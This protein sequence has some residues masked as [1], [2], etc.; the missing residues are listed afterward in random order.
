TLAACGTREEH[1]PP[2]NPYGIRHVVLVSIDTLRADRL[3]CYGYSVLGRSPS[4][5]ID[6]LA[7]RGVLFERHLS[8][9]TTTLASHTSL[10]TGT[11]P[12]THGVPR[13]GFEVADENVM[14]AE[15]LAEAGFYTA[16][17]IGAAPLM[18]AVRFD[19][20][21]R[22]YDFRYSRAA[23][24]SPSGHQRRADEVTDA[25]LDWLDGTFD[26]DVDRPLFLFV[27]YFDVHAPYEAP[28]PFRGSFAPEGL[29]V[30][31]QSDA[32]AP[33]AWLR[34]RAALRLEGMDG[35]GADARLDPG[36]LAAAE[37]EL[38]E[39]VAFARALDG[40]YTAELAFVDHELGRLFEGL[41]ARGVLDGALVVVTSDHGETFAEHTQCF[42]HG[43]SV[44]DSEAH[45][46]LIVAFPR[47]ELAGTRVARPVSAVDVLPGVLE[48]LEL[49]APAGVEGRSLLDTLH[50]D[51]P[52][53]VVFSE[54][55][56]P[57]GV[58][59]YESLPPWIN[60][61]KFQAAYDGHHKLV[62]RAADGLRFL[63]T[64]AD[65][66]LEQRNL[67][68]AGD[69]HMDLAAEALQRAMDA[70]LDAAQPL[71]TRPVTQRDQLEA[72]RALGYVDGAQGGEQED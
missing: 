26:G 35:S 18:S 16:G 49:R 39:A 68:L 20:G 46:P 27:H 17:F 33:D 36:F 43:E 28:E 44:Y 10:M 14:L 23:D 31:M 25:A 57:G 9:A 11:H 63:F 56:K 62:V 45:T 40:E 59:E 53:R 6:E 13:N 1:E 7:A 61:A 54:A 19:Q 8:A 22:H 47:G 60:R 71:P 65:D 50:G 21:F 15:I 69:E 34:A 41:H 58:P 66:P 29:P 48:A 2:S 4:P 51:E 30:G 5:H 72:L 24:G 3:G 12:A 67:L 70:R 55:T 64:P 32:N 52:Q 38:P 37:R 42:S